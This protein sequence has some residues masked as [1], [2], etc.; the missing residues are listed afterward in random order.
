[1]IW[2]MD[3]HFLSRLENKQLI[4]AN[5]QM[6]KH[7]HICQSLVRYFQVECDLIADAADMHSVVMH[8]L[9]RGR[10]RSSVPMDGIFSEVALNL[11][12]VKTASTL[13]HVSRLAHTVHAFNALSQG[14]VRAHSGL[15]LP[16]RVSPKQSGLN[17]SRVMSRSLPASAIASVAFLP[18]SSAPPFDRRPIRRQSATGLSMLMETSSRNMAGLTTIPISNLIG[19]Q[20]QAASEHKQ[21]AEVNPDMCGPRRDEMKSEAIA[22]LDVSTADLIARQSPVLD[23]AHVVIDSGRGHLAIDIAPLPMG[24]RNDTPVFSHISVVAADIHADLDHLAGVGTPPPMS[25]ASVTFKAKTPKL[26]IPLPRSSI[27]KTK[28][29]QEITPDKSQSDTTSKI[30]TGVWTNAYF[31]VFLQ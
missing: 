29:S 6:F 5:F 23:H 3:Q 15:A 30:G 17:W 19:V 21:S 27:S 4:V 18:G 28:S 1:M 31:V 8:S 11:I 2:G 20:S 7:H 12:D 24:S 10:R 16:D 26:Q 14:T 9:S 13:D 22:R 25:A